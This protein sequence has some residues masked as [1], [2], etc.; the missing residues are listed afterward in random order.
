[1]S[2]GHG[3][4]IISPNGVFRVNGTDSQR[5]INGTHVHVG[6]KHLPKD[7]GEVE[8]RWTMRHVPHLR[9]DQLLHSFA[10]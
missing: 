1:M 9:F 6:G 10:H 7:L 3:D 5:G 4:L 2:G 8:Y